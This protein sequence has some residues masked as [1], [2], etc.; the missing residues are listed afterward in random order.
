MLFEF[1]AENLTNIEAALKAGA[2][3]IELCDNLAVGG[4][5]PSLGVIE[6]AVA[7]VRE[8][9]GAE[10]RAIIRPRGG[11]FVYSEAEFKAMETDIRMASA[12]GIDGVVLGCL[13]N[14]RSGGYMLDKEG[15]ARLIK[16]A[17]AAGEMR[18]RELGITFH[19]AF[20]SLEAEDQAAAID[21]LVEFGVD[22]I[23]THGGAAGT[24]I[25]DNFEHLRE[26]VAHA[27]NRLTILPGGGISFNNAASVASVL[28]VNELH[29]TKI[30]QL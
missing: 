24:P 17:Q 19:M 20:D 14:R 16:V 27:D 26:L 8:F 4:T 12:N 5:T 15:T 22:H 2:G 30:V 1:C 25:E 29:G 21:T 18:G 23:L 28:G 11:N 7:L 3:R 6:Q 13:K 9:E 10:V